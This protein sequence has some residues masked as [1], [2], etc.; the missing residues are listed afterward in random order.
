MGRGAMKL[1]YCWPLLLR[2]HF[3]PPHAPR[4]ANGARFD[5]LL[6][7]VVPG[8]VGVVV[9]VAICADHTAMVAI[10]DMRPAV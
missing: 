1:P 6:N 3:D 10:C 4:E 8:G 7:A 5:D 9:G 2:L